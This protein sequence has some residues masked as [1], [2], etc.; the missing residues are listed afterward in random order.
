MGIQNKF[1]IVVN[2]MKP[3]GFIVYRNCE[4][5]RAEHTF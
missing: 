5:K 4:I 2:E 3:K 1:N